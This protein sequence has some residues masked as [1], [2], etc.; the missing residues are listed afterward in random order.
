MSKD[1]L[2]IIDTTLRDG[3]QSPGSSMPRD[4]KILVARALELTRSDII[5][6]GFS[7]AIDGVG[8]QAV[9]SGDGPVDAC[10]KVSG[11]DIR[12]HPQRAEV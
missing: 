7:I 11:G 12:T 1:R 10:F 5:E 8:Q 6:V 2:I 4:K 3:E 9:A